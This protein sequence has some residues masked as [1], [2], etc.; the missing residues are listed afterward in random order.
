MVAIETK[1]NIEEDTGKISFESKVLAY[2]KDDKQSF[3]DKLVFE[4]NI[5]PIAMKKIEDAIRLT[6]YFIPSMYS[7]FI[8]RL[9]NIIVVEAKKNK[10]RLVRIGQSEEHI[11]MNQL[12]FEADDD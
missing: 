3:A 2:T 5:L 1:I 11:L 12:I 4:K 8:T 9:L 10:Y 7:D 6:K